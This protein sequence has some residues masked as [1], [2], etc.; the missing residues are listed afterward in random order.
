MSESEDHQNTERRVSAI[1]TALIANW[2]ELEES[3]SVTKLK[4]IVRAALKRAETL[5]I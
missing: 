1:V 4:D 5:D 2:A 3:W